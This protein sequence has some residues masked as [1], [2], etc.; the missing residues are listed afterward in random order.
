VVGFAL[1]ALS[2]FTPLYLHALKDWDLDEKATLFPAEL[3]SMVSFYHQL[4]LV[5]GIVGA[6]LALAAVCAFQW[7]KTRSK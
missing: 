3:G 4:W 1:G 2:I 7:L 5:G 6:L